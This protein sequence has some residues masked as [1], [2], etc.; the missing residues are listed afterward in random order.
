MLFENFNGHFFACK[1]VSAKFDLTKSS[2][3]D[4]LTYEVVP[5]RLGLVVSRFFT[6]PMIFCVMTVFWSALRVFF[7]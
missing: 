1:I 4:G 6:A 2:L 7:L 3:T 5:Y